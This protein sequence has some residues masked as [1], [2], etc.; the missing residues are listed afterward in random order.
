MFKRQGLCW[1]K[2]SQKTLLVSITMHLGVD[3]TPMPNAMYSSYAKR[4][5]GFWICAAN[6]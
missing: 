6:H 1:N 4:L 5:C 3:I 2:S